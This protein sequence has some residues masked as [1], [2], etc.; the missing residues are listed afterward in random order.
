MALTRMT[1]EQI[2]AQAA[3]RTPEEDEAF[4]RRMAA[5]S[6]DEI[7]QQ[8]VEDGENPNAEPQFTSPMSAREVRGKLGLTQEGF[9]RLLNIPV[10]TLR[11][12]EQNRFS[13]DPAART[14]LRLIDREPEAA[15]RA[16]RTPP[17]AA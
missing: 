4:R 13:L 9:A 14:L 3:R 7:R 10:A 15:L 5:T 8:M 2:K 1:M 11:N 12:W 16:L 6:E 17:H